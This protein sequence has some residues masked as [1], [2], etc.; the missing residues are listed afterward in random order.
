MTSSPLSKLCFTL[1]AVLG[2]CG[3]AG[4]IA[5][6]LTEGP[7]VRL[8][9]LPALAFSQRDVMTLSQSLLISGLALLVMLTLRSGFGALDRFFDAALKR[10]QDN[11]APR[12]AS[13]AARRQV[14]NGRECLRYEDGSV[15]V[16]TLLGMRRFGSMREAKAF[17]ASVMPPVDDTGPRSPLNA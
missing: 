17:I 6:A 13:E 3:W 9:G 1:A 5:G 12:I 4:L 2:L 15:E 7:M 8:A 11:A 16:S 14:I 10:A